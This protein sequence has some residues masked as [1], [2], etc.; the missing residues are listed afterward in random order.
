[1]DIEILPR[2]T[3]FCRYGIQQNDL[4]IIPDATKDSRFDHNPLVHSDPNFRFYAGAP[5]I[6]NNGL[7]L[8]TLCLFDSKPNNITEV[9]KK[10][11]TVLAQ[12]VTFLMEL[13]MSRKQLQQ[14][15]KEI[16]AKN[17]S[18]MKIAQLQSHQIRQ[19]LTTIM[20][21]V[22]LIKEGDQA[23]DEDWIE[24]FEAATSDFD[25]RI[26][27]IVSESMASDDLRAIRFNG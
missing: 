1:M 20:G 17:E 11:L 9:Q 4:F 19:P 25:T 12:Q 15:I 23:V 5:L 18:L 26:H 21:L 8:G 3:S 13:E 6:L 16:E 10:T 7:K 27:A 24:M 2:E 22:N 14:Q